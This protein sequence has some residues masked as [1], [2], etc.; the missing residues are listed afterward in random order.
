[1]KSHNFVKECK[2]TSVYS[3]R[4]FF[5]QCSLLI[6]EKRLRAF[7][8]NFMPKFHHNNKIGRIMAA[9]HYPLLFYSFL[10]I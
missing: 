6:F 5:R 4:Q 1:M 10:E 2:T 9:F 3:T 8:A 7:Q